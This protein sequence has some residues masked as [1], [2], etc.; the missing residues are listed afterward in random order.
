MTEIIIDHINTSFLIKRLR[1]LFNPY[2]ISEG[3]ETVLNFNNGVGEGTFTIITIDENKLN[4]HFR[5]KLS[6]DTDIKFYNSK[7]SAINFFYLQQGQMIV[8]NG[9]DSNDLVQDAVQQLIF[10]SDNNDVE[11]ITL[12]A[13]TYVE[14]N[15]LKLF[16]VSYLNS[17]NEAKDI[18]TFLKNGNTANY[19]KAPKSKIIDVK[20]PLLF[21][22][23]VG[24]QRIEDIEH[25]VR[26]LFEI[27]RTE[28]PQ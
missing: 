25:G 4:I 3:N 21:S 1:E 2:I 13:N 19:I 6:E 7:Q 12:P 8:S 9:K 27:Q 18:K 15:F 26:K 20:A 28:I 22:E 5:G 23:K 17:K 14:F 11:A 16:D 24:K 10:S